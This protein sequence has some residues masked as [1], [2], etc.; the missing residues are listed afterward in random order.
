[1]TTKRYKGTPDVDGFGHTGHV[2]V[3]SF[4]DGAVESRTLR[5]RLDEVNHSPTGF[6][7]GYGGSG[8]AQLA[9][10]ILRDFT[11]DPSTACRFHQEFKRS[12]IQALRPGAWTIDG[13]RIAVWLRARDQ[14]VGPAVSRS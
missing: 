11:G 13:E 8:P 5:L 12:I 10:A 2:T 7:W 9:Y 14:R 1:M 4:D 6:A 3:L